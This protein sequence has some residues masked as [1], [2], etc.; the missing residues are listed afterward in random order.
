MTPMKYFVAYRYTVRKG[1]IVDEGFYNEIV[2]VG[3]PVDDNETLED[4]Q[5]RVQEDFRERMH[6]DAASICIITLQ[7]L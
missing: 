2:E 6:A 5:N 3:T 1:D 7:P 4:L